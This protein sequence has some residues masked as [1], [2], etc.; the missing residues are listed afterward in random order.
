M[1]LSNTDNNQ[2]DALS[3]IDFGKIIR[4]VKKSFLWLV[5]IMLFTNTLAFVYLRYTKPVYQSSSL[6]KLEIESEASVLGFSNPELNGNIKG[7]SGEIELLRSRLFFSRVAEVIDYDVAY[8]FYGTYLTNERYKNSPFAVQYEITDPSYYDKPIDIKLIDEQNFQLELPTREGKKIF[9]EPFNRPITHSGIR[10]LITRT[11]SYS[12]ENGPGKY[13]FIINSPEKVVSY[14]KE[15]VTVRPENFNANTVRISL[16]DFNRQK[17]T[18]F[19]NAI[20]TLYLSYTKETKN[21]AITQKIEFLDDQIEQTNE[22]LEAFES[23]FENFTIENRTISLEKDIGK[24]IDYLEA[25][26]SQKINYQFKL[27]N[28]I[29][30]EEQLAQNNLDI[31]TPL[32]ATTL[33]EPIP[34]LVKEYTDLVADRKL[35]LKSYNESTLVIA[36][37]DYKIRD[38]RDQAKGLISEYKTILNKNMNILQKQEAKINNNFSSLPSRSTEYNKN[39][40]VYSLQEEIFLMLRQSK[41]ELEIARAGTVN[42]SVILSSASLPEAPI[43]PQRMLFYGVGAVSGL[44]L[45]LL[46][47]AARYFLHNTIETF[48]EVEQLVKVPLLGSVPLYNKGKEEVSK[49]V[50]D[51]NPKSAIS[52]SFRSIRTSM[53]FLNAD[54]KNRM[55]TITSTEVVK[56]KL[57]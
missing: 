45:C 50:I 3:T 49:L 29:K 12:P 7:L 51:K 32:T 48:K 54:G 26:D 57:S 55:I 36:Q 25:L 21:R 52:E 14:L 33:P 46:F 37:L 19:V 40:R 6:L 42:K 5:L 24:S 39:Q 34:T 15:N 28:I 44:I 20:D 53:D 30:L 1:E 13:Y 31:I 11:T 8:H 47:I 23:Y 4:I 18:D 35:K 41:T 2:A 27:R 22:K 38:I 43:H 9:N 10:L 17:A 16:S 56:E